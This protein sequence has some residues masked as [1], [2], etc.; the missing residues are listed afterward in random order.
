MTFQD[1]PDIA[2][3]NSV[4]ILST[5]TNITQARLIQYVVTGAGTVRVGN[6]STVG[7]TRGLPLPS[8]S[9]QLLPYVGQLDWWTLGSLGVYI[10]TG[11]TLSIALGI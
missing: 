5:L 3:A 8:G 6:A 4:V 11:T 2:G 10:P 1:L 7:S 9:G